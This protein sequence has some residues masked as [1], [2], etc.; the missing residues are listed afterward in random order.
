MPNTARVV[1]GMAL[2]IVRSIPVLSREIITRNTKAAAAKT[3][4]YPA[5][6]RSFC[7]LLIYFLR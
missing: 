4:V 5:G 6:K 1:T 3:I 7:L 2:S